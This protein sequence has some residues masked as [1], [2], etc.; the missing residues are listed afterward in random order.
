[1][2]S[3]FDARRFGCRHGT[4]VIIKIM[5]MTH[6]CDCAMARLTRSLQMRQWLA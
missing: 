2:D 4:Y 3:R 1:M 6:L 5:K